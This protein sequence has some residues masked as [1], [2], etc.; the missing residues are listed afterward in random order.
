[1]LEYELEEI[2]CDEGKRTWG[3]LGGFSMD[4][5]AHQEVLRRRS[6]EGW[7]YVGFLPERQRTEEHRPGLRAPAPGVL[8]GG[9]YGS[10]TD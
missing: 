5:A 9:A 7:R 6:A 2:W 10:E 3:P 4:S 8:T 1:M